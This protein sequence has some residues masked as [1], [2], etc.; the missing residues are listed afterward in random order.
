MQ[1]GRL[2]TVRFLEHQHGPQPDRPH[3]AGADVDPELLHRLDQQRRILRV[4]RNVRSMVGI[5]K[6]SLIPPKEI[7]G[8][9]F[10]LL[11]LTLGPCREGSGYMTDAP[12]RASRARSRGRRPRVPTFPNS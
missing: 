5:P 9:P 8:F 4:E 1:E 2:L 3:A 7:G 10:A 12:R 6:V 11:S